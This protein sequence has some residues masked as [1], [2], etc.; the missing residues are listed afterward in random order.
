MAG[1]VVLAATPEHTGPKTHVVTIAG[2][3][4]KPEA[5]TVQRG[6]RITWVNNDFFPHSATATAGAFDSLSILPNA[7]WTYVAKTAGDYPYAC[8]FHPTMKAMLTVQ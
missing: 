3:R 5:L 6:D 4:F 8:S 7:S 1:A 2:M